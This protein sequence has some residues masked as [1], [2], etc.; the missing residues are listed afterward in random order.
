MQKNRSYLF[1]IL[2]LGVNRLQGHQNLTLL[3]LF[4]CRYVSMSGLG[5]GKLRACEELYRVI[6]IQQVLLTTYLFEVNIGKLY[7][8]LEKIISHFYTISIIIISTKDNEKITVI[9]L[10]FKKTRNFTG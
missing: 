3:I 6:A 2:I 8:K 5:I 1:R 9:L 7:F 10:V 4:K